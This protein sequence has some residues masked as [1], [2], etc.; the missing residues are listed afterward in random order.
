MKNLQ[1]VRIKTKI[2]EIFDGK[3]D[4]L[5]IDD[6]EREN[7]AYLSRGLAAYAILMKTSAD[8]ADAALSITDGYK[9]CGLDAIY[10]DEQS[11]TLTFVQSKWISDGKSSISQGDTLKLIKGIN[12]TLNFEFEGFNTKVLKKQIDIEK[13]LS[14]MDY[15]IQ[16]I[17]IY[18]SNQKISI[19]S[20]E[21]IDE[22][23]TKTNDGSNELISYDVIYLSDIY[24]HMTN[25]SANQSIC[26]DDVM[27][28]DWGIIEQNGIA[29]GYYGMISAATIGEWWHKFG[30]SLLSKNIRF[31]KGDTEVNKGMKTVLETEP[32]NFCF[33]NNGI[34]LIVDKITRKAAYST[35]RKTGLFYLE[36]T[37][38]VNGAQTVGSIGD[39]YKIFP[40]EV[41]KAY[42]LIQMISLENSK[43]DFGNSITK[44]SN[45]QN[46]IENKDF[47]SMD[48]LHDRL[49]RDFSLDGIEYIYKSGNIKTSASDKSCNVDE[50][51]IS[52]GCFYDDV[53]IT[54]TIKSNYGKIFEEITKTPY[55]T[56][57]NNSISTYKIW[58]CIV[59]YR[60]FEKSNE[61]YKNS[62][63]GIK[64]LLSIHGN[65]FLLHM[66]YQSMKKT[67]DFD[68]AYKKNDLDIREIV[69]TSIPMFIDE[70]MQIKSAE[71]TDA[72]PANIF[73]NASRCKIIKEK[74]SDGG[75]V[76]NEKNN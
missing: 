4:V 33:Y 23:L 16:I 66:I 26:L 7:N 59:V 12:K 34:K 9:D 45:T 41:K 51:A 56:I 44:L 5:D 10:L 43:D 22:L 2:K 20:K 24:S 47:I 18:T 54:A 64:K 73:K 17:I 72:Y 61:E 30:V 6:T 31:F 14:T 11:K 29:K 8:D 15:K 57:F 75:S 3:I 42:V 48:P 62:Q 68:S 58:N 60:I 38:I 46:R 13:A 40:E 69:K 25:F 36:N 39:V 19:E 28:N 76:I 63:T 53:S 27:I 21:A 50:V 67:I 37:S 52:L 35:E 49:R 32:T 71:F 74:M 55:K 1:V 65:R 70:I